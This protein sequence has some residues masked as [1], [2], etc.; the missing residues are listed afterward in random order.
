MNLQIG[1]K[2]ILKEDFKLGHADVFIPAGTIFFYQGDH[3]P[4]NKNNFKLVT[5]DYSFGIILNT[6]SL[7][8]LFSVHDLNR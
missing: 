6:E 2:Y 1:D 4:E 8:S 3:D 7:Y 5:K